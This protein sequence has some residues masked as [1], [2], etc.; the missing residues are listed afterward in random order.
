MAWKGYQ[1]PNQKDEVDERSLGATV[2]LAHL[3]GTLTSAS[4]I[5]A[6]VGAF[7]ALTPDKLSIFALAHL[8]LAAIFAVAAL[9][10]TVYTMAILPTRAPNTNFVRSKEVALFST[11]PLI[12]V[13]LAGARFV[14]AIC[15]YLN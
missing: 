11:I 9:G 6:G 7:V 15:A 12:C 8:K 10:S 3:N 4:I 14:L 5:A 13:T 1:Q 2:I